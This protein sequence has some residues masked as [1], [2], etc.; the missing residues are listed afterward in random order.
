[1]LFYI[2][3]KILS[4]EIPAD[5][6]YIC[7]DNCGGSNKNN[8]LFWFFH[9]LIHELNYFKEIEIIY[10]V[11]GHTKFSCDRILGNIKTKYYEA[12]KIIGID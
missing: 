8:Y 7:L 9:Y 4:Q 5:K 2:E 10:M 1:M 11:V 3:N 6:L 12:E